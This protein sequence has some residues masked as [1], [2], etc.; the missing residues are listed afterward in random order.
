MDHPLYAEVAFR[1][2]LFGIAELPGLEHHPRILE[3]H[4]E[5]VVA[6]DDETPW[7]AGFVNW[8]LKAAGIRGTQAYR[9]PGMAQ[10]FRRWGAE[11]QRPDLGCIVVLDRG[12]GREWLDTGPPPSGHVGFFLG[13]VGSSVL[14]LGGNQGNRVSVRAYAKKRV[15][16][17]HAPRKADFVVAP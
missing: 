1:E 13:F 11:L 3:Y 17:Y 16:T 10:S 8:C 12:R 15:I 6:S 7:C 5:G 2:L 9:W 14:V 4:A